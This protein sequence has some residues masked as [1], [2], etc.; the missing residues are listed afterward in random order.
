MKGLKTYFTYLQRNKLFTLV[1]VAGLG[2]S[3]MFVLL[4]ANM[5]VRQVTVGDD[6]KDIDHIYVLSNES[7]FA[8]NYLVGERLASRYPEMADWCAVNSEAYKSGTYAT[9][10]DRKT[11]LEIYCVKENFFRFF[12]YSLLSGNPDQ[13]LID[14]HSIVLTESG[15]RK[16][17]GE[18]PAEGK[19][20]HLSNDRK[21]VYTV[22]GIMKNFNNSLIPDGVEAILPF[23]YVDFVN[24]GSS[25]HNPEMNN[26]GGTAILVRFP[27]GTDPNRKNAD[28]RSFFATFFWPYQHDVF[29]EAFWTSLKEVHFASIPSPQFQQYNLTRVWIFLAAGSLI[30]LM[31]VFNYVSMCVA[32]VSYRAKEMAT[33]RLLGSSERSIFWRLMGESALF[34]VGAFLLALVLAKLVEPTA[35]DV[36][37]TRLDLFGDMGWMTVL[38]YLVG[39]ALL[40]L[41]AGLV[42]AV[43]LSH[44]HPLDVVK[45]TF[46][47]KTKAVYLRILYVVQSGLTVAMLTCALYLS[48]QIYRILHEPMGY[49]YGHVLDYPALVAGSREKIRLFRDEARKKPFVKKVCLTQG[50]PLS[51]GNNNTIQM[52]DAHNR[53]KSLSFQV[54]RTDSAFL[55]IFHIRLLDD[56]KLSQAKMYFSESTFDSLQLAYDR[57]PALH[58]IDARSYMVG[59]RYADFKF[60]SVLDPQSP[61]FLLVEHPDSLGAWNVL[62]ETIDGDLPAYKKELDT[63]YSEIIDGAPFESKWY[64]DEMREKYQDLLHLR[65]LIVAFTCAA[66]LI[67]LLGLTAMS[68][69][70]IS[71]RKRDIAIRKVF[72]SSA[73]MERARLLRFSLLSLLVGVV[74][75]VPLSWFGV[76]QIDRILHYSPTTM[77]GVFGVAFLLVAL[78][79]LGSVCLISWKAVRENPVN[80]IKT[81]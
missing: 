19:R 4:I 28:M 69:Y 17:F 77:W 55:D 23:D 33:R 24:W 50:V 57:T 22:T 76:Q 71:Q 74:C 81:E 54:F 31:A 42:P 12:G 72:G 26:V 63:L 30:L 41:G 35:S 46:R 13:A 15:A 20:I 44:Y 40:S 25:K 36:L 56:R 29:H 67:S 75:A 16:L 1:N 7:Y 70:F 73:G 18:E 37:Q 49:T 8:G 79:S 21:G 61:T 32:Q 6:I 47:R 45:G 10:D 58:D 78:I 34:T 27:Q 52:Y 48:V 39:I 2:I 53:Q 65:T 64:G 11:S 59:G 51:G 3:L 5:V 14:A 38:V 43:L 60:R 9:V 66:L 80:N 62:I 68:I